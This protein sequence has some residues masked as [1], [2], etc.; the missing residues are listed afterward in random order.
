MFIESSKILKKAVQSIPE[1]AKSRKVSQ[2]AIY[3]AIEKDKVNYTA[4]GGITFIVL[5][6]ITLEYTPNAYPNKTKKKKSAKK[7]KR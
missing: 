2:S 4:I 3:Y 5:S 1:F 6:G 7:A